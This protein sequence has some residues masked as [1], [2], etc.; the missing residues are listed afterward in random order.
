MQSY[1]LYVN[2]VLVCFPT[3]GN[4]PK[5]GSLFSQPFGNT[6][7]VGS[8]FFQLLATFRKLVACFSNF[9][10]TLQKLVACFSNFWQCSKSWHLPCNLKLSAIYVNFLQVFFNVQTSN[11]AQ[12]RINME[13]VAA[14]G[15][16]AMP[17][18]LAKWVRFLEGVKDERICLSCWCLCM[19]DYFTE[20]PSCII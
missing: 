8:L 10:V 4:I 12:T 19:E 13:G 17:T 5:V 11:F 6:P 14:S 15:S 1:H 18:R 3:F 2:A 7:K 20:C 16:E 9:L